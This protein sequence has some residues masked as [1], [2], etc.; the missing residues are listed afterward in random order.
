MKRVHIS[1]KLMGA[2][3]AAVTRLAVVI[4]FVFIFAGLPGCGGKEV[5][6]AADKD[7]DPPIQWLEVS[8][9]YEDGSLLPQG[10]ILTVTLEDVSKMDIS[11]RFVGETVLNVEGASPYAT[12]IGFNPWLIR[13]DHSYAIKAVI[14]H[15]KRLLY[16][17][18]EV[19]VSFEKETPGPIRL[20]V[21]RVPRPK[22]I[23]S[24]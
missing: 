3:V 13:E 16:A 24:R 19:A 8:V 20:L 14:R 9:G 22:L 11:S 10:S 18:T 12:S 23:H 6:I 2:A 1:V 4:G 15:Y 5:E 7:L 17:S 21:T